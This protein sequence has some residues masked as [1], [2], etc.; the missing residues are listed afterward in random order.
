MMTPIQFEAMYEAEWS[1]L[2]ALLEAVR[3]KRGSIPPP[4]APSGAR[5]AALYRRACEHLALARAR[6]YPA[7]LIER[8]ERLTSDAHQLIYYR[9]DYGLHRVREIIATDSSL[10]FSCTGV[11]N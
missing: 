9:R 1:E 11:R 7:Y 6:Y 2:E 8:L 3:G 4:T 5:I 10:A